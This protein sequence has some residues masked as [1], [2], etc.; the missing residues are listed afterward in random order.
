FVLRRLQYLDIDNGYRKHAGPGEYYWMRFPYYRTGMLLH[1]GAIF[2]CGLL[3]TL[4]F[5]P[6]I[7]QKSMQFHRINGNIIFILLAISTVGAMMIT[8]VSFGGDMA[9]WSSSITLS[10][11]TA[12]A[13]ALSWY[14]IKQLQIDQHRK[15]TLRS[16]FYMASIITSRFVLGLG[17]VAPH[18]VGGFS[19]VSFAHLCDQLA[20]V[21][22][23]TALEE[24]YPSCVKN[25]QSLVIV[26]V[27]LSPGEN[28]ASGVRLSFGMSIW[29]ALVLHAIGIEI[30]IRLT[31][32][33]SERLRK[34]SY[35]KQKAA[36]MKTP[37]SVGTVE[38]HDTS[39]P[40]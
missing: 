1:L 14:N 16:M 40:L 15:W 36:G 18:V 35:A 5:I 22:N 3:S 8:G 6:A 27:S 37:G 12:G 34:V 2:P 28:F 9:V 32:G 29:V 19:N 13:A 7:R 4:Q 38:I 24:K 30:Y 10:I 21:M 25:P 23:Q 20:F 26:L 11:V 39:I 17:L 31:S 33:E